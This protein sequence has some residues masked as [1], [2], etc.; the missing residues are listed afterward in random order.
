M[1]V[2]E[3]ITWSGKQD[4]WFALQEAVEHNCSCDTEHPE[5]P[6]C[7]AHRMLTDQ[8]A[9]N[10]LEFALRLKAKLETEEGA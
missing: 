1:I 2:A 8:A 6:Q 4:D 3:P 10:R 9:L 7:A 5:R